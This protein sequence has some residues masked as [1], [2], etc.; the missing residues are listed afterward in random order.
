MPGVYYQ[1]ATV[2]L[3]SDTNPQSASDKDYEEVLKD[4]YSDEI[5]HAIAKSYNNVPASQ[6]TNISIPIIGNLVGAQS[7][8]TVELFNA[9]EGHQNSVYPAGADAIGQRYDLQYL[10]N[11]TITKS[12][13]N[14]EVGANDVKISSYNIMTAAKTNP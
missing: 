5:N 1:D 8:N 11:R 6:G 7:T 14:Y 12:V 10:K 13:L 9:M 3:T 4:T 2:K